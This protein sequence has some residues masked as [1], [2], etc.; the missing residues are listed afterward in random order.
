MDEPR[1]PRY[2]DR[3]DSRFYQA[4]GLSPEETWQALGTSSPASWTTRSAHSG[5]RLCG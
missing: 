5:E 3:E 1:H 2:R 4:R